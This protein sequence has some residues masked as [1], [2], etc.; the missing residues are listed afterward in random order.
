MYRLGI[1]GFPPVLFT[2]NDTNVERIF[3]SPNPQPYVKD[4][5]HRLIVNGE[6]CTNPDMTGTKAAIH[7]V[8]E[9]I[10]PGKTAVL[11][12]RLSDQSDLAAPLVPGTR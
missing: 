4:A 9:A 2:E 8:F 10:P 3:N 1:E 6:D 5:F 7:Y 11:R 12:Y